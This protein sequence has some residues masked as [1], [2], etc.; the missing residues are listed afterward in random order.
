LG[1]IGEYGSFFGGVVLASFVGSTHC[2]GMCG[3]LLVSTTKTWFEGFLFHTGRLISYVLVGAFAGGLGKKI[4]NPNSDSILTQVSSLLFALTMFWMAYR[5][6]KNKPL[7]INLP[8]VAL[9]KNLNRLSFLRPLALG[10][11]IVFIPC[12]W[13]YGFILSAAATGS[14][15]LGG[16]W[17]LGFWVG[18]V[19]GLLLGHRLLLWLPLQK[20]RWVALFFMAVGLWSLYQRFWLNVGGGVSCLH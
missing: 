19:P 8:F 12:G 9:F 5:L 13:L 14:S 20:S 17:M 1:P 18:T 2:V 4:L 3:P 10:L 6:W 16:L 15:T 11:M 7:H